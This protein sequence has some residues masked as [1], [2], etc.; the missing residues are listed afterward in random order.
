M[1]TS[2]SP[3]NDAK[4]RLNEIYPNLLQDRRSTAG[5][6]L[7]AFDSHTGQARRVSTLSGGESFLASLALALGLSDTVQSHTGGYHFQ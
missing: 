3:R 2:R 7:E 4:L 6:D 1:K 5:L